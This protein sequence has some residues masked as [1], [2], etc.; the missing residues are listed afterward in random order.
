MTGNQVGPGGN[1]GVGGSVKRL[2]TY[3]AVP[4]KAVAQRT[5]FVV[6][7]IVDVVRGASSGKEGEILGAETR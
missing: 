2:R 1:R 6:A 5:S 3:A 4:A 7:G